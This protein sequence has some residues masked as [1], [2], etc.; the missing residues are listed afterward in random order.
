MK[1]VPR[2]ACTGVQPSRYPSRKEQINRAVD[3]RNR[4]AVFFIV[5]YILCRKVDRRICELL[6]GGV[7]VVVVEAQNSKIQCSIIFWSCRPLA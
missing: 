2:W 1:F 3:A 7:V 5:L 4:I 6:Y